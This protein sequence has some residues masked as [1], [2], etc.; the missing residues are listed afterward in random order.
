MPGNKEQIIKEILK[1]IQAE[2]LKSAIRKAALF[3]SH[4]HGTPTPE[5]DIDVLVEFK[6]EARIGLFDFVGIQRRLGDRIG[7][8]V[9]LLTPQSL[10]KYFRDRV[11]KE[12]ETIYEG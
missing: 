8:K 3:G 5:S 11:L 7:R 6:P 9:D 12:A 2:P 4:L 10:S 1:A